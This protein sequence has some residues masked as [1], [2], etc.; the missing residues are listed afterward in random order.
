MNITYETA[1]GYTRTV[2]NVGKGVI[3]ANKS[4]ISF[5]AE[6]GKTYHKF[7]QGVV[8][9]RIKE[10]VWTVETKSNWCRHMGINARYTD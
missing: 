3:S 10:D 9:G 1:G 5:T 8:D 4:Y 2:K 7:E 6:N